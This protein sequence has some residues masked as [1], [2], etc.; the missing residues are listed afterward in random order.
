MNMILRGWNF[1]GNRTCS[2]FTNWVRFTP[3][4]VGFI[5]GRDVLWR[6]ESR[7]LVSGFTPMV[8]IYRRSGK[9]ERLSGIDA[10]AGEGPVEGFKL[11]LVSGWD[12]RAD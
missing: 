12:P 3:A 1:T 8:E 11:D 7:I 6:V 2:V 9:V 5:A 4:G 10:L